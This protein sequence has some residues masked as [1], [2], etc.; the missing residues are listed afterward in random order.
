MKIC[1]DIVTRKLDMKDLF[2]SGNTLMMENK[3]GSMVDIDLIGTLKNLFGDNIFN[4]S[5]G[6]KSE[7]EVDI[8]NIDEE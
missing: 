4:L 5:V 1:K 3:D 8:D 6:M 2:F 7:S